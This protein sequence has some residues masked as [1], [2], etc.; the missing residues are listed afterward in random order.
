MG[1]LE[2]PS[3]LTSNLAEERQILAG[4]FRACIPCRGKMRCSGPHQG[5]RGLKDSLI[6]LGYGR[7]NLKPK[8]FPAKPRLCICFM[9][10][11]A[12][13]PS[14]PR[15]SKTW[16]IK[17]AGM[18]ANR[19]TQDIVSNTLYSAKN[20]T[21]STQ[22]CVQ[23]MTWGIWWRKFCTRRWEPEHKTSTGPQKTALTN[24]INI[25]TSLASA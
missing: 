11:R 20:E 16:I 25:K 18:Q 14:L 10:E 24:Q 1:T 23:E 17:A 15:G 8:G 7:W 19:E 3:H 5:P 13:T 12:G 9:L 2:D 22:I 21:C 4:G 6:I